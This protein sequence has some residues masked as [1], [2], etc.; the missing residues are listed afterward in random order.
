[1]TVG[2][3]GRGKLNHKDQKIKRDQIKIP[4]SYFMDSNKLILRFIRK[5]K[6]GE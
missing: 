4:A 2:V 6:D 1:M 3:K 5:A